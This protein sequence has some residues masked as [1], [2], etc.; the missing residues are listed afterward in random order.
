MQQQQKKKFLKRRRSHTKVDIKKKKT[1]QVFFHTE[2]SFSHN[3]TLNFI[4]IE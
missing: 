3:K 4:A 1:I 2:K